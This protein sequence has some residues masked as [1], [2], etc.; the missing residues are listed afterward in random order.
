MKWFFTA[1]QS[2]ETAGPT[3]AAPK[4]WVCTAIASAY[5]GPLGAGREG[6]E[7]AQKMTPWV[8]ATGAVRSVVPKVLGRSKWTP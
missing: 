7:E 4:L 8:F 6:G 3:P 2:E 1:F 5:L